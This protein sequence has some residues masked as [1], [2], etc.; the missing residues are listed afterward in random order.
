MMGSK[1]RM[2]GK[3]LPE[4]SAES[5]VYLGIDTCKAWLDVYV[6]P[7]GHRLRVANSREGLKQLRREL[8]GCGAVL[9]VIEA[10]RSEEHTSELQSLMRISYAVFCLKKKNITK[11]NTIR[12]TTLTYT[13]TA[14][15]DDS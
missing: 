15:L 8:A 9:A 14:D 10:T 5:K 6:H 13:T 11:Q 7:L 3:K 4:P 12:S 2:Q 1:S